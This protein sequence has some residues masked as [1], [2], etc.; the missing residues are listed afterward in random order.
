MEKAVAREV[1][2]FALGK[3]QGRIVSFEEQV[4]TCWLLQTQIWVAV[5]IG[6]SGFKAALVGGGCWYT[7]MNNC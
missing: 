2:N 1:C 5:N 3:I 6:A 7:D 4:C